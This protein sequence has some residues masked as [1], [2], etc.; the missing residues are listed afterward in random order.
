MTPSDAGKNVARLRAPSENRGELVQPPLSEISALL[1]E[2]ASRRAR[3]D[4]IVAGLPLADLAVQARAELLTAAYRY[5]SAYRDVPQPRTASPIV[6]AGHQPQMFHV[7]VWCKN[8]LLSKIAAQQQAAAV[9]LVVDGDT[10]KSAAL[11]VPAPP[12]SQPIS[13]A[14]EFD[15]AGEAMPYEER[16]IL[17]R[18]LFASFAERAT[19]ILSPLVP[20]PMLLEFWPLVLDRSGET[21]NLGACLAQARHQWE[22]NWGQQTLELPLSAVCALPAFDR[23]VSH[24]FCHAARFRQAHNAALAEYRRV[25]R[26]RST[27]HPV[28]ELALEGDWIETPLWIWRRED[29][30]RR[31]LF[32]RRT[33]DEWRCT[34]RGGLEIALPADRLADGGPALDRL[35]ELSQRG[36][37]LRTRALTTTLW[38]RLALGDLFLHGIGGAKYDQLTD[39]LLRQ[40]FGLSPPRFMVATATLR[41]PIERPPAGM[42]ELRSVNRELRELTFHPERF[43]GPAARESAPLTAKDMHSA[44]DWTAIKQ[45]AI[46]GLFTSTTAQARCRTIREAN[47]ALQ[48]WVADLR[49]DRESLRES[50]TDRMRA[51]AVLGSREYGFPIFPTSVLRDFLLEFPSQ[52]AYM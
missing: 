23:F 17:D 51:E 39:E 11:R 16:R 15:A 34:D 30:R 22:G 44:A 18:S 24:L 13:A 3:C 42:E 48:A 4:A 14:V 45:R 38:A 29:P 7:G 50:L 37:K 8:F 33:G 28:P 12:V 40:F 46:E 5:S 35:A 43:I 6:L 31:R 26:V 36:V 52:K 20:R 25:N 10:I 21:V 19:A 47:A 41:L 9:N 2:N 27:K 49:R 32:V 1:A